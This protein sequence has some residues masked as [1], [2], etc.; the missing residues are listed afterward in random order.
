[1]CNFNLLSFYG[2]FLLF[3][4]LVSKKV[5]KFFRVPG[6][7]QI[8]KNNSKTSDHNSVLYYT[9]TLKNNQKISTI[10]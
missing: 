1:M 9:L 2:P 3:F 8:T 6:N 5:R 10:D 4:P 7:M